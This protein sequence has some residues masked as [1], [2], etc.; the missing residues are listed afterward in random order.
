MHPIFV[1]IQRE[2]ATARHEADML[3]LARVRCA[4]I[5]AGPEDSVGRWIHVNAV[6]SGVEKVYGGI[7]KA[8]VRIARSIDRHVPEGPDWHVTLLQRMAHP[9]P[10]RRPAVLSPGSAERLDALRAFRHRERH[11]YVTDLEPERVLAIAAAMPAALTG[12]LTD[13]AS[14]RAFMERP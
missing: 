5:V 12:V 1:D 9:F 3:E 2:L 14:F 13:V 10:E 4:A 6:A 7:E 8:L 11:S